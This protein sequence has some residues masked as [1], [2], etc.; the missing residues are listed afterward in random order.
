M[1]GLAL[2]LGVPV[3]IL[4][5]LNRECERRDD[6][7]PAL[8]DIRESGSLE[9]D[10]D[11]VWFLF[12]REYYESNSGFPE[13]CEVIMAKGRA[14]GSAT[15]VVGFD[16]RTA[17]FFDLDLNTRTN[18]VNSESERRVPKKERAF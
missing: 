14:T 1:K 10:A 7:R 18:Y 13:A 15:V 8:S 3:I 12:R 4:S 11:F 9:Q 16:G 6:K 2:E 5:Q 17:S